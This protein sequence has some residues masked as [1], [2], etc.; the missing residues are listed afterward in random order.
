MKR[1]IV[2]TGGTG[3]FAQILKKIKS[4]YIMLYPTKNELDIRNYNKIKSYIRKKKPKI[5]IHLAGLSRPMSV[6]EKMYLKVFF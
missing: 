1:K 5:V 4:N 6:H 3:R 2:V